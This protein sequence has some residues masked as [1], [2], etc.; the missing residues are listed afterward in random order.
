MLHTFEDRDAVAIVT[1]D[2]RPVN[3]VE[4]ALYAQIRARF[5]SFDEL[6]PD[7]SADRPARCRPSFLRRK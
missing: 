2:R 5:A 6:L 3:A 7:V 1:L 4:Q